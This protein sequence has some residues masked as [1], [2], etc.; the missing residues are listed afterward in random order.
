MKLLTITKLARVLK[1]THGCLYAKKHARAMVAEGRILECIDAHPPT[2]EDELADT[3]R[4]FPKTPPSTRKTH[5]LAGGRW[6][7]TGLMKGKNG[8]RHKPYGT[9]GTPKTRLDQPMKKKRG[10]PKPAHKHT[11]KR[12]YAAEHR[13]GGVE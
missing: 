12:P 9:S 4:W 2:W 7:G 11:T 6:N 10:L 5:A 8:R 1:H 13:H 3:Q